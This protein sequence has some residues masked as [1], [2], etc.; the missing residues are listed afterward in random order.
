MSRTRQLDRRRRAQSA[1]T[2]TYRYCRPSTVLVHTTASKAYSQPTEVPSKVGLH[3]RYF[4]TQYTGYGTS[5]STGIYWVLV[6]RTYSVLSTQKTL[7]VPY[8]Y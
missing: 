3:T 1:R 4:C 8:L 6:P 2:R 5:S 7:R